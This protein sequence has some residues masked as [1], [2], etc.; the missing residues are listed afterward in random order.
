MK[1]NK[2][3]KT[4][5]VGASPNP[6]RYAFLAANMLNDYGY[7]FFLFGVKNG[8]VLGRK[9][10]NDWDEIPGNIHTVTLYVG[11]AHQSE[12]IPEILKLKPL[13]IIF[14]PGTENSTFEDSAKQLGIEVLE[15]CTLVLLRT[16][17]Y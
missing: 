9:I 15:A 10:I 2:N 7:D 12:I 3:E 11:P 5:I 13:R 16:G 1:T 14:N 4:L 17:Q 6:A 8:E